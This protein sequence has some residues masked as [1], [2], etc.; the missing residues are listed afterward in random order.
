[1]ELSFNGGVP[2][3]NNNSIA[4]IGV[5]N[6]FPFFGYNTLWNISGN[7]S[8]LKGSHTIKTGL[9]IEHTTRPAAR[10]SSFNGTLSF[11]T[12]TSNPLNTN[13]GFA[14]ALIGAV[15]QYAEPT[16]PRRP[17]GVLRNGEW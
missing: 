11:N 17:H 7:V 9:F 2:S 3:L 14:N 15:Q 12:D 1:M 6:R 5:E 8:K 10:A 13:V 16:G 4:S